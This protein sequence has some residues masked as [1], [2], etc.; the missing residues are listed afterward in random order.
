MRQKIGTKDGIPNRRPSISRWSTLDL[1]IS[2][3]Y[4]RVN[5]PQEI[6]GR[7][8]EA[9]KKGELKERDRIPIMKDTVAL[10]GCY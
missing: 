9:L 2:E 10:V 6:F 1:F 5:Y 8:L 7:L 4:Y 3:G